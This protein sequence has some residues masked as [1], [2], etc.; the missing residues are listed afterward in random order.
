VGAAGIAAALVALDVAGRSVHRD[1]RA[2]TVDVL[3]A[4]FT[5][6]A[7]N[8]AALALLALAVLGAAVLLTAIASAYRHGRQTRGFLRA[9]P[10]LGPLPG[11]PDVTVVDSQA[12]QA[13]CAGLLRPRVYLSSGIAAMLDADELAAVIEHEQQHRRARDP[14]RLAGTRVLNQAL[15][16]LPVLRPLA[17][18]YDELAEERADAAAVGANGGDPGALAS[19][20]L[21]FIETAPAGAA[22]ISSHRVESLLGEPIARRL[23]LPL[24]AASVVVLSLLIV[25]I[26]RAS[27]AASIHASLNLPVVSAQPCV[28]VLAF[29][30][31]VAGISGALITR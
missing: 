13:F 11:Y 30:P 27:A 28:L 6:P 14:L 1:T 7:V 26:W 9:L 20:L 3:G 25:V 17:D 18:R 10:V 22:G 16:F 23:P 24:L 19:A 21:R 8:V 12:P 29:V 4:H 2:R 31:L 15:F 5:Y